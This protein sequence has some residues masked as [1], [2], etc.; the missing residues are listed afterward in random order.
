MA[1]KAVTR[2]DHEEVSRH[3][4]PK[5]PPSPVDLEGEREKENG[6]YYAPVNILKYCRSEF[7]LPP[8]TG[9]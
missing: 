4:T 2:V 3:A 7:P 8:G 1:S 6:K 9:I 5:L